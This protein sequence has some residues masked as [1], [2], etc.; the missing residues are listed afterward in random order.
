MVR[1]IASAKAFKIRRGPLSNW[2]AKFGFAKPARKAGR[3]TGFKP[4]PGRLLADVQRYHLQ[5]LRRGLG[6]MSSG[7]DG[8]SEM[9]RERRRHTHNEASAGSLGPE[10]SHAMV[11]ISQLIQLESSS[12]TDK[13]ISSSFLSGSVLADPAKAARTPIPC[14]ERRRVDANFH[15]PGRCRI[16]ARGH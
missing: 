12:R 1:F 16:K 9:Q 10:G 13:P 6:Q 14:H 15:Y 4:V 3:A 7:L 2:S 5:D 11:S 8:G